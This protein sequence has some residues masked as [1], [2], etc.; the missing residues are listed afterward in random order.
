LIVAIY[1]IGCGDESAQSQPTLIAVTVPDTVVTVEPINCDNIN[2][3]SDTAFS[4]VSRSAGLCYT[5]SSNK[6]DSAASHM[7]GGIAVGDYD[8]DG[9]LNFYVSLGRDGRLFR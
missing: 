9:L 8:A 7:S 1:V 4:D 5:P 6:T 3:T 2:R